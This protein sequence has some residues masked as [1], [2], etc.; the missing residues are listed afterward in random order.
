MSADSTAFSAVDHLHMA[1][2]LRLAERG[3]WTTRPNPMVGCVI[4]RGDQVVGQGWHQRAGGP[5]AE[6]FALREAG[7]QALYVTALLQSGRPLPVHE[8]NLMT[9]VL[10]TLLRSASAAQGPAHHNDHDGHDEQDDQD[11]SAA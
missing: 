7:A 2:A 10:S 11:G 3:R 6:V 4:A 9:D 8:A 5:H 1:N